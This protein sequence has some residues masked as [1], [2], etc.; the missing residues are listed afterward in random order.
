VEMKRAA[1]VVCVLFVVLGGVAWHYRAHG[2]Q[3]FRGTLR[4]G[5]V[6]SIPEDPATAAVLLTSAGT[7]ELDVGQDPRWRELLPT[8]D[9]KQVVVRGSLRVWR[10][11]FVEHRRIRVHDLQLSTAGTTSAPGSGNG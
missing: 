8:L 3:E 6:A 11:P 5:P 1:L 4:Y 10:G 7:Y 9:G 2:I